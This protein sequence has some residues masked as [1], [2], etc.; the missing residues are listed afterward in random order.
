MA[1]TVLPIF[2]QRINH[3]EQALC[4]RVN[5]GCRR[6]ALRAF[7]SA[8]SRLG[9]GPVWYALIVA[10]AAFD[11]AQGWRVALAMAMAGALGALLYKALKTRLVRE[12]PF[13]SHAGIVCGAAPLDRY[14]FPSGHTLHAVNF[15]ILAGAHYPW[16]L[17][18][19]VPLALA[20][21]ASRVVLGLHYPSDVGAGA[22][23]G[24]ALAT[25]TLALAPV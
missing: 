15:T 5:R 19:L 9:D 23:I 10:V 12:R 3:A 24:A 18:V 11:A 20:M 8:V 17:P 7:F 1:D 6:P 21:A 22:L 16:L 25:A 13:I 14:S 4:L 2:W